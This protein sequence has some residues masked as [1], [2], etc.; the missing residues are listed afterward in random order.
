MVY[1]HPE[2]LDS[3]DTST[4]ISAHV[5]VDYELHG[6]PMTANNYSRT[7]RL[8]AGAV[9]SLLVFG[10]PRVQARHVCL[11]VSRAV[12]CLDR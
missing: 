12:P 5:R 4:P 9:R 3:L 8:L 7:P 11:L 1:A 2:Y 6:C 10:L